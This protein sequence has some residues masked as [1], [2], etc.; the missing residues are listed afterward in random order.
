M[1]ANGR[2]SGM[3]QTITEIAM[4]TVFN[5]FCQSLFSMV[6]EKSRGLQPGSA[7]QFI[8][9]PHPHGMTLSISRI[10][11]K[12]IEAKVNKAAKTPTLPIFVAMTSSFFYKSVGSFSE[13]SLS[14]MIP[15]AVFKPTAVMIAVPVP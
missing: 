8:R 13:P 4:I 12:I 7:S 11:L 3:A 14:D 1:T 2:P 5:T 9:F 15:A 6:K 10:D